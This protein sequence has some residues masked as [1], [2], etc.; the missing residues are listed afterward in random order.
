MSVQ[1]CDGK[2]VRDAHVHRLVAEA[3]LARNG[4]LVRHLDGDPANNIVGNLA[5]GSY[6]DNEA[7]K[8]RYGRRVE[9]LKHHNSKLTPSLVRDIRKSQKTDLQ[10]SRELQI[11]RYAI[12]AARKRITWK[13]VT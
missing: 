12:Y 13:H 9:G 6:T 3:F 1:L 8:R 11:A 10:L 5:W 7:D 2:R 4:F